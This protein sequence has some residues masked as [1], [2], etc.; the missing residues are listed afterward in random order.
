MAW[1]IGQF[2]S[3]GQTAWPYV[4]EAKQ[5]ASRAAEFEVHALIGGSTVMEAASIRHLGLASW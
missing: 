1:R 4:N 3:S 2:G 5:G